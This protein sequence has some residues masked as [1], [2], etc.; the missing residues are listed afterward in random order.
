MDVRLSKVMNSASDPE[1]FFPYKVI[2]IRIHKPRIAHGRAESPQFHRQG[3]LPGDPLVLSF[4]GGAVFSRFPVF[5][6]FKGLLD[7]FH[8]GRVEALPCTLASVS[9]RLAST[10]ATTRPV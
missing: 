1:E 3:H 9:P 7:L 8:F 5:H 2:R 10:S 4:A 6:V